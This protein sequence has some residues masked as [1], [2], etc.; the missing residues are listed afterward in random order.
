MAEWHDK[1]AVYLSVGI[2]PNP[3]H[4]VRKTEEDGR[5]LW[6]EAHTPPRGGP[7][8]QRQGSLEL[9]PEELLEALRGPLGAKPEPPPSIHS[10]NW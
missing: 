2:N 1:D 7:P 6:H 10:E 5:V 3:M 8:S 9:T 4:L